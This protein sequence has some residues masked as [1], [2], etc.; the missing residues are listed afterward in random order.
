MSDKQALTDY[1]IHKFL[2][3]RWSPYAFEDCG[4]R[5]SVRGFKP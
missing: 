2:A 4:M 3:E 5:M 1:P